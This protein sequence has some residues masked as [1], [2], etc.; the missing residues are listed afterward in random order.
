VTRPVEAEDEGVERAPAGWPD[1]FVGTPED[2]DAL[3]VLLTLPFGTPRTLREL[4]L[5]V[6][7][8]TACLDRIRREGPIRARARRPV[9]GSGEEALARSPADILTRAAEVGARMVAVGDPEYPAELFARLDDP[10]AGFFIQGRPLAES[11]PRVAVVGARRCSALGRAVA[12][13]IGSGLA[14]EGVGTV[15]GA[16]RGIDTAAHAGSLDAGA[17][18]VAVLGSGIDVPYPKENAALLARIV[19][20]GSVVSEHG[21]GIPPDAFRF[22]GRNRLVAALG[23]A[24]VVVEGA[25]GSGSMISVE[26]ALEIG[27]EVF[28]VPGAI[29]SPLSDVP[30]AIIREGARLIRGVQ[31]LI[32]DLGL[33]TRRSADGPGVVLTVAEAAIWDA[34]VGQVP[35][36][37]VAETAGV[38]LADA[39]GLLVGLE[40]RGLVRSVG[41]RWERRLLE[42]VGP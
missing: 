27:R 28:A 25:E 9:G 18:T 36:D 11:A 41:G 15:S 20:T 22:P 16:A 3:A 29:T 2:R 12:R 21:P 35:A 5:E 4:A 34:V 8:A 10:P 42:E 37:A 38:G 39:L 23:R 17:P 24:L 30:H 31:D 6:G 14:A 7:T 33:R 32:D 40:V 19:Q 1:A 13:S 26:H